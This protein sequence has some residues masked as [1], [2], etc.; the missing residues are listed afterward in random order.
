MN[1]GIAFFDFDGTIT[2]KDTLLEFIK[3]TKGNL[4]FRMG[5]LRNLHFLI[6]YKI[7]LIPNQLAKEKV[8]AHFFGNT[9]VAQFHEKCDAFSREIIPGLIRPGAI[10][11]IKKLQEQGVQVVIV[12]ASPEN[13]IRQWTSSI[14]ADLLATKL[15]VNNETITGKIV[16]INCH[17]EEKV[18]RI[19]EHYSLADYP[20]IYAYG[21]TSG[22][23]PMLALAHYPHMK[24]FR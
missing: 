2:N 21:D 14:H 7:K 18:R 20:T 17:G 3:F 10:D 6:A 9:P 8:L 13:W 5:F 24:P 1:K 12:S 22:D 23:K 19:K 15:E 11:E 16:G 4:A